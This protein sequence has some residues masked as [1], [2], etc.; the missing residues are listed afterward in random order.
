MSIW[1]KGHLIG[2]KPPLAG[3]WATMPALPE[4]LPLWLGCVDGGGLLGSWLGA[5]HLGPGALRLVLAA[6]L[7]VAAAR[8]I[9]TA[10]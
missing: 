7:L 8:V 1:N 10:L 4:A 6:L 9:A 2:Q 3:A 5:R